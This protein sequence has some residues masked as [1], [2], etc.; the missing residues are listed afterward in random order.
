MIHSTPPPTFTAKFTTPPPQAQIELD[1]PKG[2]IVKDKKG[3]YYI[4]ALIDGTTKIFI[5]IKFSEEK[6]K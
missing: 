6:K 5:P 3:N 4:E 2:L 1:I